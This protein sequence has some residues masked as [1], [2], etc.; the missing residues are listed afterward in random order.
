LNTSPN[1]FENFLADMGTKPSEKHSID[2]IDN[3]GPYSPDNCRWASLSEQ[4]SNRSNNHKISH[5]GD[6]KTLS[7]WSR[8]LGIPQNTIRA[9]VYKYGWTGAQALGFD[10]APYQYNNPG[11]LTY[12]GE[13]KTFAQWG[14]QLNIKPDTIKA[15]VRR[16]WTNAQALG[17]ESR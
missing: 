3:D 11:I 17:F 5:G 8:K 14:V 9:R 2:R 13:D 4:G 7:E 10:P 12:R 6:S 1:A 16:G 15:R